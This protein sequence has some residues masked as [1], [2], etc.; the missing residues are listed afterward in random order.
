MGKQ[1]RSFV[2]IGLGA[3]GSV[4]A[5][6]LAR[7]GN[8]VLGIDKD[9]RR[10]AALAEQLSNVVIL[11]ATDEGALREAGVDRYDVG[12]VSI[13]NDLESN[14]IAA[15]N[16]RLIG[17]ETIWAKA[18]SRTHHRILSKIGADRV[19]L[20]GLEMGRHAA[21][22]LNNP[23]VQDYVALG[24]GFSV[25][26]LLIPE[27][28]KGRKLSDLNTGPGITP[29]GLMRGTEYIEL[30]DNDPALQTNDRLLLLGKR[31]DLTRFGDQL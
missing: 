8:R 17:V 4:V 16:M 9:H 21:Q 14:V 3:F 11:D 27:R 30:R 6:E 31:V 15:M 23:A 24:N 5:T 13:G 7:F 26:N 10:V 28:L 2:V 19:I 20:P 25:V 1:N 22:M 29:L 12:L 18:E